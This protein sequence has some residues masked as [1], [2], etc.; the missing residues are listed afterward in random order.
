MSKTQPTLSGLCAAD[1]EYL[2]DF[3]AKVQAYAAGQLPHREYQ[4]VADLQFR[5]PSLR[6]HLPPEERGWVYLILLPRGSCCEIQWVAFGQV[7][8]QHLSPDDHLVWTENRGVGCFYAAY[9]DR[10]KVGEYDAGKIPLPAEAIAYLSEELQK[11]L[12]VEEECLTLDEILGIRY[13][14]RFM[15]EDDR[16]LGVWKV[17]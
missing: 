11:E 4:E 15:P 2:E 13:A 7:H 17:E 8:V 16:R 3:L 9:R 12:G 5:L 1:Q 14:R 10:D 6:G